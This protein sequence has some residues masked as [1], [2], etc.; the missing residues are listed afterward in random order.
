MTEEAVKVMLWHAVVDTM[1]ET[2]AF[3]KTIE[4][5]EAWDRMANRIADATWVRYRKGE[6]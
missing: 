2:V 4:E 6:I 5:R 1:T 3:P